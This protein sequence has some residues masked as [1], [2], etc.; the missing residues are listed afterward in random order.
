MSTT[1]SR[2]TRLLL[3]GR[4]F[5]EIPRLL[6]K[7]LTPRPV[8]SPELVVLVPGLAAHDLALAPLARFLRRA[9]HLVFDSGLGLNLGSVDDDVEEVSSRVAE[10]VDIHRIRASL[11]GWSLGGVIVREVARSMPDQVSRVI[12]F[13]TPIEGP[14]HTSLAFL[15][16]DERTK[17]IENGIG[18][19]RQTPITVPITVVFS[20]DDGIVDWHACI[21]R[22]NPD[23]TH[24]EVNSAHLAMNFDPD[25]WLIV[26]DVL[27]GRT[28]S[29]VV[30][31]SS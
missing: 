6:S 18:A 29:G 4:L 15:Y 7:R 3:E 5:R 2:P 17:E 24:V 8:D 9:G 31:V 19:A 1:R 28:P 10:L 26:E 14:R 13:G 27:A 11:V 23:V 22:Y 30:D 25:I 21:D 12:T 16:S 20:R